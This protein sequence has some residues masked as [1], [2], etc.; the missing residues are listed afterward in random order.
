MMNIICFFVHL[1]FQNPLLGSLKCFFPYI[2]LLQIKKHLVSTTT[3]AKIRQKPVTDSTF[4]LKEFIEKNEMKKQRGDSM[5]SYNA[6][7]KVML[8]YPDGNEKLQVLEEWIAEAHDKAEYDW[9]Y[10][11]R[12]NQ[13]EI[14]TKI[15]RYDLL[16]DNFSWCLDLYEQNPATF[17]EEMLLWQFKW[18]LEYI[19]YFPR[20][21]NDEIEEYYHYYKKLL[22]EHEY[23][24]RSYYQLKANFTRE[25]GY[26][27][28][29][30]ALRDKWLNE[31]RDEMSDCEYCEKK[32]LMHI[33]FELGEL[34]EGFAIAKELLDSN[35]ECATI[36]HSIYPYLLLP[37]WN[38]ERV[39]QAKMWQEQGYFLIRKKPKYIIEISHMILFLTMIDIKKAYDIFKEH[40]HL[41][42]E[43]QDLHSRFYFYLATW[44]MIKRAVETRYH[45]EEDI[46]WFEKNVP[47][48]AQDFDTRNGNVHYQQTIQDWLSYTDE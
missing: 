36:P 29:L 33:H 17:D 37:A 34:N 5:D 47:A 18:F 43:L 23:S 48:L 41:V 1:H 46:F 3:N 13:N 31:P 26:T 11:L 20:I 27:R 14:A 22:L 39:E 4:I 32:G 12:L 24:L 25:S 21:S 40:I 35:S 28:G 16:M 10:H 44:C 38:T 45:L 8:E 2:K 6:L 19:H 42:D 30:V 9:E 7:V 15:G